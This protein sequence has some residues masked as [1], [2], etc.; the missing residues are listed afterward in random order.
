MQRPQNGLAGGR[1]LLRPA[2][3]PETIRIEVVVAQLDLAL[4]GEDLLRFFPMAASSQAGLQ[5]IPQR[6]Q[7]MGISLSI[8]K[9]RLM[10][11]ALA[12]VGT[13]VAFVQL[14]AILLRQQTGQP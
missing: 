12:P 13:L 3:R 11:W 5:A 2:N 9:L 7:V 6:Q 4:F 14:H 1:Q 10:E 8:D